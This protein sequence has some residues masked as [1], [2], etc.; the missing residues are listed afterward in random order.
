MGKQAEHPGRTKGDPSLLTVIACLDQ[1][2]ELGGAELAMVN[3]I[4]W[5]GNGSWEWLAVLGEAGPLIEQLR[6]SSVDVSV[7]DLPQRLRGIR[8][9]AIR[10]SSL[11]N[12]LRLGSSLAYVRRLVYCLAKS[13][14]G[15]IH[16]NSM[17]MG[18]LGIAAG[19]ILRIPTVWQVHSVAA[20]P[21]MSPAAVRMTRLLT[22]RAADHIIC[23]SIAIAE[24]LPG[25][26]VERLSVIPNGIDPAPYRPG[27]LR[28]DRRVAMVARLAPIK[29]QHIFLQ[30]IESVGPCHPE[31]EFV[32]AGGPLFGTDEYAASLKKKVAKLRGASVRLIGHVED[33]P[34]LLDQIDVYVHASVTE[35]GLPLGLIE[36]M[37]AGKAIIATAAGGPTEMIEDGVSGRLIPPGDAP[38]LAR[39]LDDLL[40]YPDEARSMG[41]HAREVALQRYD[42]KKTAPMIER[43]YELVLA[44]R[45]EASFA[46]A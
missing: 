12:P 33:V 29:G 14:A 40:T 16:I 5:I 34:R 17:R 3:Q 45:K 23:P 36:A 15:L 22:T 39:A 10:T 30:A 7:V 43:V 21:A 31:V 9:D 35:E 25:M 19:R 27:G 44:R 18:P 20:R 38:A 13:R 24:T 6:S 37:M 2:A 32:I 41:R 46:S 26:P 4:R 42:I 8:Q 28:R 1:T 11:V